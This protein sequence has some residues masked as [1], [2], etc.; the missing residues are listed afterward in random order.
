[1]GRQAHRT[2]SQLKGNFNSQINF[3]KILKIENI[4]VSLTLI[5]CLK[6]KKD[7]FAWKSQ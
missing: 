2:P 3:Y 7:K 5:A 6:G 1:M 4:V